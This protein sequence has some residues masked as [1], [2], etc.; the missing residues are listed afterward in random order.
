MDTSLAGRGMTAEDR[1]IIVLSIN[2]MLGAE[3]G[4]MAQL[5]NMAEELFK[6]SPQILPRDYPLIYNTVRDFYAR[7]L[8]EGQRTGGSEAG[9]RVY[10]EVL[11]NCRKLLDKL[12]EQCRILGIAID[13]MVN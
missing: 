13:N 1:A 11:G 10:G 5:Q 4:D 12:E 9:S 6:R 3:S 7:L 2:Y 8:S